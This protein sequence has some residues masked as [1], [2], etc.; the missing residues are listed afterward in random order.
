M[1]LLVVILI[2]MVTAKSRFVKCYFVIVVGDAY[3]IEAQLLVIYAFD[4]IKSFN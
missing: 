3:A 4:Y 2:Q 1:K